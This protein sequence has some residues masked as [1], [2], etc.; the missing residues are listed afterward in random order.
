MFVFDMLPKFKVAHFFSRTE[1]VRA[2]M[3][4]EIF[5]LIFLNFIEMGN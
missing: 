4:S 3:D 2:M 5:H 1:G